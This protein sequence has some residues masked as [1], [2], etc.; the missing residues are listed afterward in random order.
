M[1][2]ASIGG[3]DWNYFSAV[4]WFYGKYLYR[5][6][7]YP[8]GL[9]ASYWGGATIQPW[10]TPEGLATCNEKVPRYDVLLR[11]DYCSACEEFRMYIR[12]LY[13]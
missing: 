3:P 10:M 1:T 4:C 11:L 2:L 9:I 6:R 5:H 7:G 12:N 13:I 8:I